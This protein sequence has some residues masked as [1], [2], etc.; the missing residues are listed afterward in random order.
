MENVNITVTI[1]ADTKD[2][3]VEIGGLIG[4][5]G[6]LVGNNLVAIN[7]NHVYVT[8]VIQVMNESGVITYAGGLIRRGCRRY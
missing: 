6:F 3:S 7:L 1:P 4:A 2:T 8:G 5:I